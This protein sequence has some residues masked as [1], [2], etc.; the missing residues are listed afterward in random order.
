MCV[1]QYVCNAAAA[2]ASIHFR[3][4]VFMKIAYYMYP[5]IYTCTCGAH[6]TYPVHVL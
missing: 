5:R 6:I 3:V 4:Y 2:G 1:V